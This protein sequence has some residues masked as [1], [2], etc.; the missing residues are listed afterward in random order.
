[1]L[2]GFSETFTHFVIYWLI[3]RLITLNVFPVINCCFWSRGRT[4]FILMDTYNTS[5]IK[6]DSLF[7]ANGMRLFVV[8][9]PLVYTFRNE[10][11]RGL[12]CIEGGGGYIKESCIDL[13]IKREHLLACVLVVIIPFL[14][15]CCC[16]YHRSPFSFFLHMH[17]LIVI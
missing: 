4:F 7:F 6:R 2:R 1:M 10:R 11:S 15:F 17:I 13:I 12:L 5:Y 16:I 8:R 14:F 9:I 3:M